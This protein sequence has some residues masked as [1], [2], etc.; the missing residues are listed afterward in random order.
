MSMT[1]YGRIVTV[2]AVLAA[3]TGVFSQTNASA[4]ERSLFESANR[5]RRTQGLPV[6][7]WDEALATAARK[8]AAEMARQNSVAHTLPGEPSL[9]SR[10]TKAGARFGW[11][12]ENVIQGTSAAEVHSQFMKS[13]N[14]KANIL[15]ADM[16]SV[17]MGVIERGGQIFV[18]EDFSKAK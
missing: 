8:H 12:S 5:A 2:L 11:L 7:K 6:L 1:R 10:A 14:H 9:P 16:D 15:D 13:P 3:S 17:G 18:A 4:A